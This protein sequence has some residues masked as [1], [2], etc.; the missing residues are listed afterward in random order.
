MNFKLIL[1][2]LLLVLFSTPIFALSDT[3][4]VAYYNFDETSGTTLIDVKGYDQNGVNTNATINQTGKIGKDYNFNG[5]TSFVTLPNNLIVDN[6]FSWSFW[7][8]PQA[9]INNPGFVLARSKGGID[10]TSYL[11]QYYNNTIEFVMYNTAGV[12]KVIGKSGIVPGYW[13]HVVGVFN[14]SMGKLELYIDGNKE[15]EIDGWSGNVYTGNTNT[16]FAQDER[17]VTYRYKGEIDEVGYW[18]KALSQTEI[19]ELYNSG[20]G[21]TYPFDINRIYADFD[22]SINNLQVDL[23]DTSTIIGDAVIDSWEWLVD[24]VSVSTDQNYS[25]TGTESTDYNVCLLIEDTVLSLN[26][27][28]CQTVSIGDITPPTT[29]FSSNQVPNTTDQNITLTCTDNNSGCQYINFRINN[30][31]WN[32]YLIGDNPLTIIYSGTGVNTIQYFSTDNSD[33]NETIKTSYFTTYGNGRFYF[34]DENTGS[35]LTEVQVNFNGTDYDSGANN[36]ID[37]NFQTLS[38][39]NTAYLFTL[40]KSGYST[41]Y[42]QTDL[43][44]F[45]EFDTNFALLPDSLDSDVPFKVYE[46]D[47]TTIYSNTFVEVKDKDTNYTVGRLKTNSS[48]EVTFNIRLDDSNYWTIVDDGAYTYSPVTLTILYPKDEETLAQITERW[49]IEISQNL[50]AYYSDL[51]ASKV[52]YLLPNTA[53]PYNIKIDDMNGNYFQRTYSKIYPGNPLTDT[54]QPYLVKTTTGLLTTIT[55]KN[56]ITN[57]NISGITIKIYKFISGQGRTLVEQVTTDNKGQAISLLVLGSEYEFECYSGATFIKTYSITATSSTIFIYLQPTTDTPETTPS[58]FAVKYTPT[59]SGLNKLNVGTQ[60]FTQTGFNN[61]G[62]SVTY[63]SQIIQGGILSSQS[64]TGSDA[65]KTFSHTINWIDINNDVPVVSRLTI[66]YGGKNYVY[67]T[68][69][70]VND[71][72]GTNYNLLEGLSTGL[73]SDAGCEATGICFPLMTIALLL[74]IGLTIWVASSMGQLGQQT[75][76]IVLLL[77][78]VVFTYLS[79]IP[80]ELTVACVLI[81][82]AFV[83]N[84]RRN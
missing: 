82:L 26:D 4:L 25:F 32:Y 17:G 39:T 29:T 69:Y 6:N 10:S 16:F 5:T 14:K 30:G 42:Y 75:A 83:V 63:T 13:Y 45:S 81:L 8:R 33:N 46:T 62:V 12:G 20:N 59:Y 55:T 18:E 64:Y 67:Q 28:I 60:V 7:F 31:D 66:T 78:M 52:I 54:L 50:Y 56:A 77:A 21:L 84:E 19:T 65:N 73:R 27:S 22:Y 24:G 53:L 68:N 37:F 36:Y 76:G 35:D 58:G 74:S 11:F 61:Y 57:T 71:S 23:N 72:F 2:G 41:R 9:Q 79:W 47:E 49:K 34:K 15:N 70:I 3:D 43:N 51:N 80:F 1:I 48:G 40:S 38:S 44:Y